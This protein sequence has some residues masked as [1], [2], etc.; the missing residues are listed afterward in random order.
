[1]DIRTSFTEFIEL[2][3]SPVF[4]NSSTFGENRIRIFQYDPEDEI[5]VRQ[6]LPY[7]LRQNARFKLFDLYDVI[8]AILKQ[9]DVLETYLE[10]EGEGYKDLAYKG[11]AGSLRL[12]QGENE[13]TKYISDRIHDG[14][15]III[16]GVGKAYPILRTHS[17]IASMQ[18]KFKDQIVVVMYPGRYTERSFSL[19]SLFPDSNYYRAKLIVRGETYDH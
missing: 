3:L 13:I 15:I 10:L 14:D 2:V 8:I 11:I 16:S 18:L 6:N 17:L 4:L 7:I 19:F 12:G 1:M 9:S 5:Y